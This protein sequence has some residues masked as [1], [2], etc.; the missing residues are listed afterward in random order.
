MLDN[1]DA[2]H[3]KRSSLTSLTDCSSCLKED[4]ALANLNIHLALRIVLQVVW[5]VS[6][7]IRIDWFAIPTSFWMK[8][9]SCLVRLKEYFW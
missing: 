2:A 5:A 3:R 9:M 7:K 8:H 1:S 6:I 4:E